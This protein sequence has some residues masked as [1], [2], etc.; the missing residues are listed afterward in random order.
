MKNDGDVFGTKKI[1][2]TKKQLEEIEFDRGCPLSNE[3]ISKSN[4]HYGA[5]LLTKDPK[6]YQENMR[7]LVSSIYGVR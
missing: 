4:I 1:R 5:A 3:I 2:F 7:K 6:K